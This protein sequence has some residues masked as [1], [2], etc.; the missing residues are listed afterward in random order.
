MSF[1]CCISDFPGYLADSA[2][3]IVEHGDEGSVTR[4]VRDLN[5]THHLVLGQ[6]FFG[7][8]SVERGGQA[9]QSVG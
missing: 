5:E 9:W 4:P 7:E 1:S 2:A 8:E 6:E 3:R